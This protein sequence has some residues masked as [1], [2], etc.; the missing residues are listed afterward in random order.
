MRTVHRT[1]LVPQTPAQMYALV[2]DVRRYPEFLPWCPAT[3]V[4]SE[5]PTA[6]HAAIDFARAG[7]HTLRLIEY[8]DVGGATRWSMHDVVPRHEIVERLARAFG[9]VKASQAPRGSAPAQR[10]ELPDG[11]VFGVIA[12]RTCWAVTRPCLSVSR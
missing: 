2:N 12:S 9:S 4:Y 6:M 8:M 10:Y 1:A 3:T 7:G 11:T 5:T